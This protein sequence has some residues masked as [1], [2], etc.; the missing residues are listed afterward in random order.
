M[1]FMTAPRSVI[2]VHGSVEGAHALAK[3]LHLLLRVLL[4][5]V[6]QIILLRAVPTTAFVHPVIYARRAHALA[7]AVVEPSTKNTISSI[8]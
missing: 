3:V 7:A 4:Q 8:S 5:L 6:T 2:V 1:A